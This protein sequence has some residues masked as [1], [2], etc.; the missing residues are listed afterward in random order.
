MS[1]LSTIG[2]ATSKAWGFANGILAKLDPYFD[3]VTLLLNGNPINKNTST[4][5]TDASTNHFQITP[6]GQPGNSVQN[7][8]QAG[9][10]SNYFPSIS[11]Y[12]TTSNSPSSIIGSFNS[13]SNFWI[14][15]WVYP[16]LV[17]TGGSNVDIGTI[18]GS[19]N[20]N[21]GENDWSWGV[22]PNG[23]LSLYWYTSSGGKLCVSSGFVPN[24]AW[25][26]IAINVNN[27]SITLFI[28]GV[29]QTLTGTTS[30]SSPTGT[31]SYLA[32]GQWNTSGGSNFTGYIS[33]L[34]IIKASYQTSNF[35]PSTTPLTAV[36][37]TTLLT[38]QSN[39]FIDNSSLTSTF[40]LG[41]S[42]AVSQNQPFTYT[43][44]VTYGSGYF[45]GS[46]YVYTSD[47]SS[48]LSFGS[49]DWTVDFWV[50]SSSFSSSKQGTV[51]DNRYNSSTGICI[52]VFSGGYVSA[53]Q[54][55]INT[56]TTP[57]VAAGGNLIAGAWNFVRVV[58]SSGTIY[59][60][61]NGTLA[62][63]YSDGRT[64]G[65]PTKIFSG[66]DWTQTGLSYSSFTGY[67]SNLRQIAG[68][69]LSGSTIPSAPTTV[70]SGTQLLTL[71][72]NVPAQNNTFVDSSPNQFPITRNGNTTQGSFSPYGNLWSN[73][74]SANNYLTTPNNSALT[75]GSGNYT[76]ECWVNINSFTANGGIM[77]VGA[78]GSLDNS[79]WGIE[80]NGSTNSL[81]LFIYNANNSTAI[82]TS[83]Q[84]ISGQGWIHI[85]VVRNSN[86]T[87]MY[88]N[89]TSV[90]SYSGSYTVSGGNPWYIGA[91]FYSP[92]TRSTIGYISNARIVVGTA[93][94]T[95]NF[96]PS[97]TPLTAIS[98]TSLLTCQSNQFIDN[99][100]NAFAI[101][102]N[103][104]PSVQ[105]FSPFNPTAPYSTTTIGGS[106]YTPSDNNYLS[107]TNPLI[108]INDWTVEFWMYPTSYENAYGIWGA[109]NGGGSQPKVAY[110]LSSSA[111]AITLY[112]NGSSTISASA[113]TLNQWTY[114]SI[115]RQSSSG[116]AFIHYNGVLQTSGS[117]GAVTSITSGFQWFTNGEQP[118]VGMTGYLSNGRVSNT[119]RY[120][121]SSYSIPTTPTSIDANTIFYT[122]FTNAGI[123][124]LAMQNDLQ[125]VGSA[126]VSTSVVKYGTGSL[127]FNGT[128]DYLT[129]PFI[130]EFVL[131]TS[132]WTIE[133]W[134]YLTNISSGPANII[135]IN[136][137]GITYASARITVNS[138]GSLYLLC[139]SSAS[140]WINTTTTA[141]GLV[142][143]NTWYHVAAVRNGST[144]TL[145]LNGTS[146]LTY[147]SSSSLYNPSG[148]LYIGALKY[149]G[150][151]N[152]FLQGYVDDI[153]ITNGYARYT[154][155]FTP[156]T[157]ALPTY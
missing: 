97:T 57:A 142:T 60:Y 43:T 18:V 41:G 15:A 29:S 68:T 37:N 127:S 20:P 117:A 10:Y 144:F 23:N 152:T 86:T 82:I 137:D 118:Q 80:F 129:A 25:T 84:P 3:Y 147:T 14:E 59:G 101:T 38:C 123:P 112:V 4:F 136:A 30:T 154:S 42:V 36:A 39:Q 73:Y 79:T 46:S 140:V 121:G 100:S 145:Y 64:Y 72:A 119:A 55:S 83:S 58:R 150:G 67:I 34:R 131:G 13:S 28:N 156:P 135:S 105:R 141:T 85:A 7:P 87:T 155:N 5:I 116:N 128:T 120:T 109:S 146:V 62:F 40:T 27:G 11:S 104:S 134:I 102:V 56:N 61:T 65:S 19:M 132:N 33:N 94:Y 130:P 63:T 107:T 138:D 122:A 99:S 111:S 66:A 17:T 113:P 47:A 139:A 108:N 78:P 95:S 106:A 115:S 126:Q 91:G 75:L 31:L 148:P 51:W 16:V 149:S 50:Y 81:I 114:V 124:D 52:N 24:N 110:Q 21:G 1:L 93:V 12:L 98:G 74:V 143:T 26:H 8:F 90:G 103:G 88:Y 96:T 44:P 70:V 71:Q 89:G 92:S 45:D 133:G 2:S 35:T 153:R 53:G 69:A 9:Y 6:N 76:V 32:I 77:E 49:G 151:F 54:I 157:S 48:N 125:T 22:T